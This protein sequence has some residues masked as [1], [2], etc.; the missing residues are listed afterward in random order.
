MAKIECPCDTNYASADIVLSVPKICNPTDS[1]CK[2]KTQE[3]CD[4]LCN[5]LVQMERE[6]YDTYVNY[7]RVLT[8]NK[9]SES[10]PV[11]HGWGI[12]GGTTTSKKV[13][14]GP[15]GPIN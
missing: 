4:S 2:K 10:K 7:E 12:I 14:D 1:A 3:M 11:N 15:G 13:G 6:I 5:T 8:P 9:N